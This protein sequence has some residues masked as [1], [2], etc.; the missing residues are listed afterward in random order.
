MALTNISKAFSAIKFSLSKVGLIS[1][2]SKQQTL[3]EV[4][5]LESKLPASR[6]VNPLGT[7]V[8]VP[9]EIELS[10]TSTSKEITTLINTD[11]MRI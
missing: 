2:I 7:G 9:L 5:N 3:F 11:G 6:S 8:P 4:S 10:K 1:T